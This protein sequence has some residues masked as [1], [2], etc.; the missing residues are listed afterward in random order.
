M[1]Y[2]WKILNETVYDQDIPLYAVPNEV[3]ECV[4][5]FQHA[6]VD[7]GLIELENSGTY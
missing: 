1:Q 3:A 4:T 2:I 5:C 7:I 6:K